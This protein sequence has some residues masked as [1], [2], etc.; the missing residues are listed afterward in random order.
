MP[1][2]FSQKRRII[3]NAVAEHQAVVLA[4][5]VFLMMAVSQGYL[6]ARAVALALGIGILGLA[7]LC[8]SERYIWLLAAASLLVMGALFFEA[9]D[10]LDSYY[11]TPITAQGHVYFATEAY[12]DLKLKRVN[13]AHLRAPVRIRVYQQEDQQ[14]SV[15]NQL[16]L[17]LFLEIPNQATNPGQFDYRAYLKTKGIV[18]VGKSYQVLSRLEDLKLIGLTGRWRGSLIQTLQRHLPSDIA[19]LYAAMVLGDRAG[20][21]PELKRAYQTAGVSHVLVISGLHLTLVSST[22]LLLLYFAR[23]SLQSATLVTIS[24]VWGFALLT[25][26]S[27]SIQRAAIML[28]VAFAMRAY[29]LNTRSLNTLAWAALF[30]IL[31]N[32][33]ALGDVGWQL[34][35][36]A[37]LGILLILPALRSE[38]HGKWQQLL[39]TALAA[40]LAT[41]PIVINQ[42]GYLSL[43]AIPA[44]LT[45]VP[46]TYSCL[47]LGILYLV[48]LWRWVI[49]WPLVLVLRLNRLMAYAWAS[50]PGVKLA[51]GAWGGVEITVFILF[52]VGLVSAKYLNQKRFVRGLCFAGIITLILLNITSV[53]KNFQFTFLDVGQG[54][55]AVLR[56]PDG[57][58]MIIDGGLADAYTDNGEDVII[59]YLRHEGINRI[60][61][62]MVSH[63]DID[64]FG[65]LLS[66]AKA[67]PIATCYLSAHALYAED[68]HL[69][70]LLAVLKRQGCQISVLQRGDLLNL[71]SEGAMEVLYPPA[72]PLRPDDNDTSLVVRVSYLQTSILFTGDITTKVEE[73]LVRDFSSLLSSDII[74]AAH[75]GSG[76]SSSEIFLQSVQAQSVILSAGRN[77]RYNHPHP[78]VV[79]RCQQYGMAIWRTD[80]SGAIVCY[81]DGQHFTMHAY[82][83]Q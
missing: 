16:E 30:I 2:N 62:I 38:S 36:C 29:F 33:M 23:L 21:S 57:Y 22:L 66:V 82:L 54:D 50:I 69:I 13:D 34:T 35:C 44:N 24:F 41:L 74:K 53:G 6:P 8:R 18:A 15:G 4:I 83:A 47:L 3:A 81:S 17:S 37:T 78:L 9:G 79:A 19:P 40:Q 55:S 14:L 72:K 26:L 45:V 65:G 48:P 11:N 59:P 76:G 46:L 49:H 31:F 71:G 12:A 42:F 7:V 61:A 80:H 70:E 28:T 75:H 56:W 39:C 20:L 5:Y 68:D 32:P 10:L 1:N 58:T 73:E 67:F 43:V 77:N 51:V 64:H 63:S 27:F 52:V 25:G 60:D